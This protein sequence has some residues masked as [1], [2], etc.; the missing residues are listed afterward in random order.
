MTIAL[1]PITPETSQVITRLANDYV[2][3]PDNYGVAK[4]VQISGALP[5]HGSV[6][7]VLYVRPDGEVLSSGLDCES[8]PQVETEEG[9]R[10]A[11]Y[12]AASEKY[13][14][15]RHLRPPRPATAQ[16]CRECRGTGLFHPGIS[17]G[18]CWN[19]GWIDAPV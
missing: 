1:P 12:V 3:G 16:E 11:A 4:A 8:I 6:A 14:E 17:C 9:L 15:L 7:F 18:Y 13:P 2:V 5:V 10:A 19:L